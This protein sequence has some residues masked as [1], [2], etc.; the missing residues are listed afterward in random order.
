M[1]TRGTFGRPGEVKKMEENTGI[2]SKAE[3]ETDQ[4]WVTKN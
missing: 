2:P 1:N 3:V 4:E